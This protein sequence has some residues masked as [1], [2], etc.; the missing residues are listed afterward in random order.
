[1]TD[2]NPEHPDVVS[3][4]ETDDV[5][6]IPVLKSILRDAEIPYYVQGEEA[7]SLLPVGSFGSHSA[8]HGLMSMSIHVQAQHA[9]EARA[10]LEAVATAPVEIPEPE[11]GDENES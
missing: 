2:V 6:L 7:V 11:E 10:L 3:I 4:Y 8:H 1:M 5:N 9:D